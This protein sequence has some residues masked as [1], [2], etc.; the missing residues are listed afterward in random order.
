MRGYYELRIVLPSQDVRLR[1]ERSAAVKTAKVKEKTKDPTGKR[2]SSHP[3]RGFGNG[4]ISPI[5]GASER[6][7]EAGRRWQIQPKVTLW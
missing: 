7:R 5:F 3:V 2:S 1:S 6:F 4:P